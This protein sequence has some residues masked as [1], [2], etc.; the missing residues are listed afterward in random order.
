MGNGSMERIK[1]YIKT[2]IY[3][4]KKVFIWCVYLVIFFLISIFIHECGHGLAIA[5]RGIECS[6]G[7]YSVEYNIPIS[8]TGKLRAY[9]IWELSSELLDF[10]VP[11]T[12]ILAVVG[13]I[14]FY[15]LKEER[16]KTIALGIA[17]TNSVMRLVPCLGVVILLLLTGQSYKED[18]YLMGLAV[19]AAT[20]YSW[21]IY[22]PA[23]VSILVSMI[24]IICLYIKLKVKMSM[25][26]KIFCCCGY[27]V[28]VSF[29]ISVIIAAIL[30]CYVRVNWP[31]IHFY[32]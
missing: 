9:H 14:L 3:I 25:S 21:S 24:C 26:F 28:L 22:L 18:E 11:A 10:G 27:F 4:R 12:L 29:Y 31:V 32:M 6:T 5:L 1:S 20:G 7:F 17:V 15:R 30:D 2:D 13:T 8:G 16:G 19:A 23:F